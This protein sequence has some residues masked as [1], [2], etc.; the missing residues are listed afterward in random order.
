MH[1]SQWVLGAQRID[2]AGTSAPEEV[3]ERVKARIEQTEPG[4][5]IQGWGHR[6]TEWTRE[7]TVAELDA[8]SGDHPVVLVSG[9]AHHGWLNSKAM[10]L[11]G[12][13]PLQSHRAGRVMV[14]RH[15]SPGGASRRRREP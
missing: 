4:M 12:L 13:P 7:P 8:I 1:L 2:T 5:T 14:R 11:V 3:L 9:D 15:P 10:E 6:L